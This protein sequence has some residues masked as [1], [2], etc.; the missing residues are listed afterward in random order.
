M[1]EKL[2]KDG[3]LYVD[4]VHLRMKAVKERPSKGEEAGDSG[5]VKPAQASEKNGGTS[6]PMP[7]G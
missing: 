1:E 7:C 6:P 4:Y 3:I 2:F 5:S